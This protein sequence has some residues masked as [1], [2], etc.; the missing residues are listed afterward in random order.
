MSAPME[1]FVKFFYSIYSEDRFRSFSLAESI[2]D[3]KSIS[4]IYFFSFAI[5]RFYKLLICVT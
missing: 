1:V 4:C 5:P 2:N 3:S